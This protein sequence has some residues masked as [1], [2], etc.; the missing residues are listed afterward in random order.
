MQFSKHNLQATI[1][2]LYNSVD[3]IIISPL[4][5]FLHFTINNQNLYIQL[6]ITI[7]ITNIL[8]NFAIYGN[9]LFAHGEIMKMEAEKIDLKY[10]NENAKNDCRNFVLECENKYRSQVDEVTKT[11][12]NDKSIKFVL[13]T[14][15]SSSGKTTT[16]KLLAMRLEKAGYDTLPISLDDYFVERNETPLWED[17]ELNY[18]TSDSIDWHL[19]GGCMKKLLRGEATTLPTYNF[20]TGKKEFLNAPTSLSPHGIV[21][22]EGLHAL[23][24]I[25]DKYIPINKSYKIYLSAN[26]DIYQ[27]GKLLLKHFDVRIYRRMIRDLYT[28]STSIDETLKIWQKVRLG[29]NLYIDPFKDDANYHINSFHAYELCVYKKILKDFE[30]D[31]K[32]LNKL[33]N[34]LKDFEELSFEIA[35]KDSVLQE[36]LP[37]N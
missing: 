34:R 36:F 19:F 9:I 29:E 18:E 4:F 33:K 7:I 25:I 14:G 5:V 30:S 21:V 26:T 3:L 22:I 15:P 11:I 24:P 6:F 27:N 28:R 16:S 20:A 37:K 2:C 23:N 8:Q 1:S 17:G 35:P 12:T 10:I 13:L 32:E 31:S